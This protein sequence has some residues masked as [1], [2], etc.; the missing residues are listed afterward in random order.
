MKTLNEMPANNW[1]FLMKQLI[2]GQTVYLKQI[3]TKFS[4]YVDFDY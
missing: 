3:Y 2:V 4:D 1:D